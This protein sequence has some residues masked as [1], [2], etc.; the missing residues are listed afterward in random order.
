MTG[1]ELLE[2]LQGLTEYDLSKNV[3]FE[4]RDCDKIYNLD[5]PYVIDADDIVLSI[6]EILD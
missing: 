6:S 1:K 5:K 2:Y 4:E 3:S